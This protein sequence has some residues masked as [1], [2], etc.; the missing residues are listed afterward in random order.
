MDSVSLVVENLLQEMRNRY[1]IAN[2]AQKVPTLLELVAVAVQL[3]DHQ[4]LTGSQKMQVVKTVVSGIVAQLP[5][6]DKL[7]TDLQ[8]ALFTVEELAE[9]A[10]SLIKA[11]KQLS[12]PVTG[13]CSATQ[14]TPNK[15]LNIPFPL[16][17]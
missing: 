2:G 15:P 16:L 3:V 10:L 1:V 14:H 4:K 8:A 13:C 9:A 6:E 11:N 7:K 5:I 12:G 17:R